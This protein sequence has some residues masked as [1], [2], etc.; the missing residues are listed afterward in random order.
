M[1]SHK[2]SRAI[3]IYLVYYILLSAHQ[4]IYFEVY[5]VPGMYY[6]ITSSCQKTRNSLY[7]GIRSKTPLDFSTEWYAV[8]YCC[9][10]SW[11]YC[12][13]ISWHHDHHPAD[14]H[15]WLQVLVCLLGPET[16]LVGGEEG[17]L[18]PS[19]VF[20]AFCLIRCTQDVLHF[21]LII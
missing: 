16:I 14:Q 18:S 10:I 17:G 12:C 5:Q 7:I 1:P 11:R 19:L 20:H 4:T 8:C 2:I 6:G 3:D 21:N 15:Q 9:M 13:V